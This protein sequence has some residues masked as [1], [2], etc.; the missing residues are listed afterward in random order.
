AA[1][2]GRDRGRVGAGARLCGAPGD[3]RAD[4]DELWGAV[5]ARSTQRGG[6][7]GL[8][9]AV[10]AGV[11]VPWPAD[12]LS[13]LTWRHVH[14]DDRS[15]GRGAAV[16]DWAPRLRRCD[17]VCVLAARAAAPGLAA[18]RSADRRA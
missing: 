13:D 5:P 7:C 16:V 17:G 3:Q 2:R 6:R 9:S 18:A 15:R 12:A 4:R 8:G 1:T 11:V 14:L 10:R